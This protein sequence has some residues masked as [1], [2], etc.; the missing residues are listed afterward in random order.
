MASPVECPLCGRQ[1]PEDQVATHAA[2]CGI[3]TSPRPKRKLSQDASFGSQS[4]NPRK[5]AP[6][7]VPKK[8]KLD[9]LDSP[10][11]N[12]SRLLSHIEESPGAK[13]GDDKQFK[14]STKVEEKEALEEKRPDERGASSL[15][16]PKKLKNG[17]AVVAAPLAE[18]LRPREMS[19]YQGQDAA[20]TSQL[21]TLLASSNLP[22]LILWGP[23]GCGKTSLANII[24]ENNKGRV[25]FVKMS[26]C[27]CG[28]A[29]VRDVVK[30][31]KNE[32]NMFKRKTILFMDEVHRFNKAQQDS[33]LPH[34]EAGVITFVGATTENPSF[35]LNAA[36]LSRC[37]VVA[38][39]KLTKEAVMGI[40][41]RALLQERLKG[42]G[43]VIKIDKEALNFLATIV[44]GDARC[45]LNN[46]EVVL[47][48]AQKDGEKLVD[49]ERVREVVQRATIS[50]D[51][52]GDA[53][54]AM[55]SAL[56]KSIRGS[57]DN[58]ALYWL[59]RMLRG[60]EDPAFIA[61][62]LVRCASEDIGLADPSA[63]PLAVAAMQGSQLLGKPE[64]DVLLA[65]AVVHLARA[66]KSH[67]VYQALGRVYKEIDSSGAQPNVPLHLRNATSSMTRDL[68][69]GKGYSSDLRK[70]QALDYLPE[71]LKGATFFGL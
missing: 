12:G 52:A 35:S 70:V 59:G 2:G 32:M 4:S 56:Q 50:Y 8:A 34:I 67:E 36:L 31:A 1:F 62:R 60:G 3:A 22:S 48:T 44:D 27:T 17:L 51:R 40:L 25:R 16:N 33:F 61:R 13:N 38:L 15:Q 69:W 58:A 26:A 29:E 37:R 28:V 23:P 24:A 55:A 63:L 41:N 54:Y 10:S 30:Q 46:L 14:H 49:L 45:A 57:S 68:G 66:P 7:F 64:C 9:S 19:E 47:E 6:L 53:H 42:D 11:P 21:Q 71:E 65:Q 43:E 39:E 18:R 20:L 5:V